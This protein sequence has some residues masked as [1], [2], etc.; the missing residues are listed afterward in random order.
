MKTNLTEPS[1]P[2]LQVIGASIDY[3]V[4]RHVTH[5]VDKV[6]FD[7]RTGECLMLTG[8]SGCG[9]SSILK[10]IGGYLPLSEGKMLLN[11]KPISKPGPDRMIIWQDV[12]QLFPW[13]TIAQNVAYP[14][15]LTGS[16]TKDARSRAAEWLAVVGLAHTMDQFPHQLSGGMK[17]RVA[18]ARGFA[19][20]PS[21]L[22]M[23]EPFSALDALTRLQLQDELVALQARSNTT[24][25]FV[26]HDIEEAA[27]LGDRVVV[28][29]PH[30]GRIKSI[31]DSSTPN[32]AETIKELIFDESE[33]TQETSHG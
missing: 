17:Q 21:L 1:T 27:K 5:A 10:A 11:G 32:F 16:S 25:I 24:V 22:L 31:V 29:S 23:D 12:E 4:G 33:T 2:L 8:R 20:N 15:L 30:F 14:L 6:T 3:R 26:S 9:K 18:I 28:L 19:A 7:V 13:K